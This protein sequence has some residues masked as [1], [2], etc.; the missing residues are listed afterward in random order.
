MQKT[1]GM[2]IKPDYVNNKNLAVNKSNAQHNELKT[3]LEIAKKSNALHFNQMNLSNI[4][5]EVSFES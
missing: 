1:T 5:S 4:M 2:H 3:R